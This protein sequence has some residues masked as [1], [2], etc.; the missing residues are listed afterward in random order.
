M[1]DEILYDVYFYFSKKTG[2]VIAAI[3]VPHAEAIPDLGKNIAVSVLIG[4]DPSEF[5]LNTEGYL[6]FTFSEKKNYRYEKGRVAFI[7]DDKLK[8]KSLDRLDN[9][10]NLL[11]V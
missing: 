11:F 7:P 3:A 9:L 2:C 5:G 8:E 6:N 4:H 1:A 10:K